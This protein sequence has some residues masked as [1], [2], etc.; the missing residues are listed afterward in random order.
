MYFN[1]EDGD[2]TLEFT[3]TLYPV[4]PRAKPI[5]NIKLVEDKAE[6]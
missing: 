3:T 5:S 1:Q 6:K 4:V 2:V